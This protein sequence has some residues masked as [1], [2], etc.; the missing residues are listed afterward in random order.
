MSRMSKPAPL[1]PSVP[2][3]PDDDGRPP[4]PH[5]V[6]ASAAAKNFG[7]IIDGLS[8][9]PIVVTRYGR[10]KAFILSPEEYAR[11]TGY[12]EKRRAVKLSEMSDEEWAAIALS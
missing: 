11:L 9:R 3:S 12:S 6:T 4:I 8:D 7:E 10:P 5:A 1:P 2:S